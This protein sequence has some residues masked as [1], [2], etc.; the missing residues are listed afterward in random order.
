MK[1]CY[2]WV[3]RV[4]YDIVIR[5]RPDLIYS[6]PIT[7]EICNFDKGMSGDSCTEFVIGLDKDMERYFYI[8]DWLNVGDGKKYLRET[9][10]FKDVKYHC[11]YLMAS[12]ISGYLKDS[13]YSFKI[14]A[15]LFWIHDYYQIYH[16]KEWYEYDKMMA[17]LERDK[18][19]T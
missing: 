6:K 3:N 5:T 2:E 12:F 8:Y 16:R 13:I 14:A 11:D 4:K 19:K 7:P 1:K 15:D 10:L 17:K 9:P 18:N